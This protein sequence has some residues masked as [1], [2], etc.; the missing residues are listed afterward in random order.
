MS[1]WNCW[2]VLPHTIPGW[3]GTIL[4]FLVSPS[5][6]ELGLPESPLRVMSL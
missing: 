5:F 4:I 1:G 3:V 6:E 2:L